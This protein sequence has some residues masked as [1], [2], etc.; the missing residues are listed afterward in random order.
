[1]LVLDRLSYFWDRF[2]NQPYDFVKA[3]VVSSICTDHPPTGFWFLCFFYSPHRKMDTIYPPSARCCLK[4]RRNAH[5]SSSSISRTLRTRCTLPA[6]TRFV[7]SFE[8]NNMFLKLNHHQT[9]TVFC[10]FLL[11]MVLHPEV[12]AKAQKEIDSVV[13]TDR[14]PSFSDRASLP[15]GT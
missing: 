6:W 10:H 2:V 7:V 11:A 3:S 14:L 13:G 9:I 12:L 5:R 1:M 8:V 15:F 4:T